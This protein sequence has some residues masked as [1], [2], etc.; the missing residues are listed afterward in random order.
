M[1]P[2]SR[3][4]VLLEYFQKMTLCKRGYSPTTVSVEY[5]K[6]LYGVP[7]FERWYSSDYIESELPTDVVL[8]SERLQ[9]VMNGHILICG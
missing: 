2:A 3:D 7:V 8:E 4:D 9:S 1:R 6:N 5:R